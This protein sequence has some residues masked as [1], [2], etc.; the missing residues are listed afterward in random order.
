[1]K[2]NA[3][4]MRQTMRWGAAALLVASALT[5]GGSARAQGKL[6][7]SVI[8]AQMVHSDKLQVAQERPAMMQALADKDFP[9]KFAIVNAGDCCS[10]VSLNYPPQPETHPY[11]KDP[12]GKCQP[13]FPA[14]S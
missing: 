5:A 10:S 13:G 6:K 11:L 12:G 8:G 1:M 14:G 7:V 3:R 2:K 4:D 9:G